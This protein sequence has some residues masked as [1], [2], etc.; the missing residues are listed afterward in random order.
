MKPKLI[1][2]KTLNNELK[3]Q[4]LN[5]KLTEALK[6]KTETLKKSQIPAA[7]ISTPKS[8]NKISIIFNLLLGIIILCIPLFLYYRY[9]TKPSYIEK[10]KKIIDVIQDINTRIVE[11]PDYDP[12]PNNPNNNNPNNYKKINSSNNIYNVGRI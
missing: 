11:N 8:S 10:Q 9:K 12:N 7:I 3:I 1:D 6:V 4:T 2:Y 5:N